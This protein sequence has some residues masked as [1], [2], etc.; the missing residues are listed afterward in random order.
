M[1]KRLKPDDARVFASAAGVRQLVLCFRFQRDAHAFDATRITISVKQDPS[2]SDARVIAF[3]DEARKQIKCPI[4]RACRGGIEYPLHFM[5]IAHPRLHDH[6]NSFHREVRH[7]AV[8]WSRQAT[9]AS[10]TR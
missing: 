6:A 10:M 5:R 7:G 3:R 4:R 9:T 2:N 1:S 8:S